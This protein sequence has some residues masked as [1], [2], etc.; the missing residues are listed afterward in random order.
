MPDKPFNEVVEPTEGVKDE[1][2]ATTPTEA[3]T[4][5]KGD[6]PAEPV[7]AV[8]T[9]AAEP[10]VADTDGDSRANKRIRELL[11]QNKALGVER[12]GLKQ[13]ADAFTFFA[14][15][16]D[17]KQVLSKK[18]PE[19]AQD[20]GIGEAKVTSETLMEILGTDGAR[21]LV[22]LV[23]NEVDKRTAGQ[24]V[25]GDIRDAEAD[26]RYGK[27]LVNKYKAEALRRVDNERGRIT[28]EEALRDLSWEDRLETGKQVAFKELEQRNTKLPPSP[29]SAT[30]ASEDEPV[31][32]ASSYR[33]AG[34]MAVREHGVEG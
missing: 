13:S 12:D 18:F 23:H 24:R 17:F 7:S 26:P 8:T 15:D 25:R 19:I 4:V 10:T 28:F 27:E 29:A 30:P 3:P 32:A 20:L 22:Q 11:E 21:E 5:D 33:E 31:K 1:G 16:P 9:P 2:Q 14:N 6:T 34:E